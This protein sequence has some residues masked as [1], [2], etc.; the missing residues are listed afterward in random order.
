MYVNFKYIYLYYFLFFYYFYLNKLCSTVY[1]NEIK[2][3]LYFNLFNQLC[4]VQAIG[5]R[6]SFFMEKEAKAK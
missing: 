4:M 1:I 3:N 5:V 2:C 6:R